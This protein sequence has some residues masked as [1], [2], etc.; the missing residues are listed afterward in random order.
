MTNTILIVD[1]LP[2]NLEV[3]FEFLSGV[4]FEV[5]VAV[6]GESAIQ[7]ARYIPQPDLIL[8][9]V[10]MPGM[11]GFET[12]RRL[13]SEEQLQAIPVIFMT[14]LTDTVDKV[15]GFSLGAVD[16]ITKPLQHEEV[17]A[18]VKTH[19]SLKN[20]QK[21][22]QS[23]NEQLQILT[24]RLQSE[25]YLARQI[26]Q[27]L[28][29][30]ARPNWSALDV[31][32]H[33]EPANEVSGDFYTYYQQDDT[34][35]VAVGDVSGKGMPA[36]LLMAV[37]FT[38]LQSSIGQMLSPDK[39]LALL[40]EAILPY[41][42]CTRQNCA[43]VYVEFIATETGWLMVG[44]NAGCVS[45]LIRRSGGQVEWVDVGGLPLGTATTSHYPKLQIELQAGDL[46]V[47]SSDGVIEATNAEG[48][49][50]GFDRLEEMVTHCPHTTA[51]AMLT[52]LQREISTFVGS[53][54]AH[55]DL[56]VVIIK[57]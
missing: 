36:A 42:S 39:A 52:H 45:P 49:M 11:D 27:R 21:Q 14:A 20:L 6:D 18:R 46:V 12:C 30:A 43:L 25:L 40:H 50:F 22:L 17:L 16:Y 38:S 10:M 47:L 13:K 37:S 24:E 8:L 31:I 9:D 34:Y 53:A 1:D 3:L 4:G 29:P 54:E 28:L 55:D 33:N 7:Q 26:Q 15:R 51:Q 41:T 56:T 5:N 19:L 32:C 44:A 57:I 35:I 23:Q 2:M 48:E